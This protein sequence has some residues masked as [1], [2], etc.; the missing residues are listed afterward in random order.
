MKRKELV[1]AHNVS[2]YLAFGAKKNNKKPQDSSIIILNNILK[3][4]VM[5]CLLCIT[6]HETQTLTTSV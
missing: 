2:Y 4:L 1:Q 3:N 6:Y 5:E